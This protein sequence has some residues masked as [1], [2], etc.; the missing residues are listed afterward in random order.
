MQSKTVLVV[1]DEV[2]ITDIIE[3]YLKKEGYKVFI[4]HNGQEALQ[5]FRDNKID[6][7]IL[8]LMMPV[9]NGEEVCSR[10]RIKSNVPIIMLTAKVE[11]EN[12]ISGI[13]SGADDYVKKP[14]SVRELMVR[15]SALFRRIQSDK[16]LLDIY[17]YNDGDLIVDFNSM[18]VKKKN[19]PVDLTP[20]EFKI[21][22]TFMFN[23]NIVLSR[24]QIIEKTFGISFDGFDRTIDTHI[25][26]LRQKIEDKPKKP[27]YIKTIYSMGYK[28]CHR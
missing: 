21:L 22:K 25:K 18:I 17:N 28:F 15:V 2:N 26:N 13:K 12:V 11:E 23:V 9:M 19:E 24:E 3:A 1:D 20:N 14:F 5:I 7:I 4:A 16:P 27:Q 10:I 8:D 6:L